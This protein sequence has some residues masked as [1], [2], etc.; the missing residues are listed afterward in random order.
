MF[1]QPLY[2]HR[3]TRGDVTGTNSG[4]VLDGVERVI[5][6]KHAFQIGASAI[7]WIITRLATLQAVRPMSVLSRVNIELGRRDHPTLCMFDVAKGTGHC[8]LPYAIDWELAVPR[9]RTASWSPIPT[10]CGGRLRA[11]RA[12]SRSG[13]TTLSG[14]SP[15]AVSLIE[16]ADAA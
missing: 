12:S 2:D 4:N 14:S 10:W 1:Q 11:I 16:H 6:D 8:V 3:I 5:N 7:N 15:A 13:P 9:T